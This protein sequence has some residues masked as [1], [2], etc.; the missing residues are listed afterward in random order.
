MRSLLARASVL[1]GVVIAVSNCGG[2]IGPLPP[3]DPIRTVLSIE[4]EDAPENA[5]VGEEFSLQAMARFSDQ[6][7]EDVTAQVE[8]SSSNTAVATITGQG[9]VTLVGEGESE[10]RATFSGASD[11]VRVVA[12]APP[13]ETRTLAGVVS[14]S[15]DGRGIPGALVRVLDGPN[16]NRSGST[17]G[18]GYYSIP[19]LFTGSF[20]IQ[21]TR[22]GY[23]SVERGLTL[24]GDTRVDLVLEP[25]PPPPPPPGP[26]PPP[27]GL[28]TYSITIT[29]TSNT[30]SDITP[31]TSGELVLAGTA[32]SLAVRITERGITRSYSGTISPDG[33]FS[34]SGSGVTN[35]RTHNFVG[36]ITGTVTGN[37]VQGTETV[38]ITL[39][40]PT[41]VTG[42]IVMNFTGTKR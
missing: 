13:P 40:C 27:P 3:S 22:D 32:Q 34:G 1:L 36:G 16:A 23:F 10:I 8:W 31:G 17:D 33:S 29:T 30:C 6:M 41:T 19:G 37:S 24:A 5:T 14:D 12:V 42:G 20:T 35:V 9:R 28:G 2:S 26:P 4:L 15:S 25:I 39:G 21:I 7:L 11:S 38:S 18:N